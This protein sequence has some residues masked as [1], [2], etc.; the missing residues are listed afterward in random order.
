MKIFQKESVGEGKIEIFFLLNR[1]AVAVLAVK[2]SP[3]A[4]RGVSD[5]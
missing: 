5:R 3:F 2:T 1:N 4:I